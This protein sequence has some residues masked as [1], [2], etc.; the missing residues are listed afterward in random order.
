MTPGPLVQRLPTAGKPITVRGLG[1]ADASEVLRLHGAVFSS[2]AEAAW[3][4]W[5]YGAGQ[6]KAVGVWSEGELIAHCGG[7]PR[8]IQVGRQTM[9]GMQIGDVMVAPAW[10]GLMTRS[11]PFFHASNTFY[12]HWIGPDRAYTLGFG[13]PSHRHLRLAVKQHLLWDVGTISSLEWDWSTPESGRGGPFAPPIRQPAPRRGWWPWASQGVALSATDA[14]A[15]HSLLAPCWE[16]M[17]ADFTSDAA[18]G[19]GVRDASYLRWR[20]LDHPD[21]PYRYLL[22]RRPWHTTPVGL[23]VW[24]LDGE[25]AAWLDWIGPRAWMPKALQHCH[26]AASAAGA[27]RLSAWMSPVAASWLGETQPCG[28]F[29]SNLIR[30]VRVNV[31]EVAR[32]GMPQTSCWP[33]GG[34]YD[35]NTVRWWW[36]GGDTDFL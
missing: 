6:G 2:G 25:S 1:P 27:K 34:E 24:R 12:Q 20:Y 8:T 23:V 4:E 21:R 14:A 35:L 3:Y 36:M 28:S 7:L 33:A 13:F 29:V 30:H 18:L 32:V 11:S 10:R 19:V 17:L 26:Q 9:A 5:K 15:I 22:I 16:G 31:S